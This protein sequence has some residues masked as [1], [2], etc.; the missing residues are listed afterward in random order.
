MRS[1]TMLATLALVPLLV[2]TAGTAEDKKKDE[3]KFEI[4][5]DEQTILDDVNKAREKEKLPPVKANPLLFAAARGHSANM[6]KQ[7]KMEHR[8]DGKNADDRVKAAG[9]KP[10][11]VAENIYWADY[12]ATK[13]VVSDWMTSKD[14]KANILHKDMSEA[15]VG[16][17]RTSKGAYYFTL[18]LSYPR[19]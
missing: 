9:Y 6:V 7:D 3:P 4:S 5:K 2:P 1:A 16:I 17:A 13:R 19:K 15:G 11:Q 14:H 18:V 8:L 12:N 10:F